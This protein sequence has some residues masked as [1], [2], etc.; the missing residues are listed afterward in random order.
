MP[1]HPFDPANAD[2]N[3]VFSNVYD[4]LGR[5]QTQTDILGHASTYYFAGNR[6]EVIDPVGN[7]TVTYYN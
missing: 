4:S 6:A 3:A 2:D 1:G 5:V 7:S